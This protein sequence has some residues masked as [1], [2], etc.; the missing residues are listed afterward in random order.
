MEIIGNSTPRFEYG[1]RL[2]ADWHGVDAS[3]FFQGV[4]SRQIWG[5]GFLTTPGYHAS[6]GAMPQ[7]IAGNFWK[8]DKTDAF[9]PAPYNMAGS[10]TGNNMQVQSKYLLDMSYLR[11]KNIT[12]GYT[13]PSTLLN[14][15]MLQ[16]VRIYASLENFFTF[17]NLGGL[18]IDPEVI[19]G[20]SMFNETNY[21]LGRTG[22]GTPVFKSGSLGL[23]INF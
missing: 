21:N 19:S 22:V 23:Q 20:Y 13:L 14:K 1:L 7:A 18:P 15:I 8:P 12:V 3:V 17:D 4:G 11:V 10:N 16:K 2:G 5:E 9:Y 6:D